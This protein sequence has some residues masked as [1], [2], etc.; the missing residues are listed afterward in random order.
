M[1][2]QLEKG[3]PEQDDVRFLVTGDEKLHTITI[4]PGKPDEPLYLSDKE[5]LA[6]KAIIMDITLSWCIS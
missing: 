5:M 1:N 3:E 2:I 6:L 4:Y